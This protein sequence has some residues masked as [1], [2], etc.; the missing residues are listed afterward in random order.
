MIAADLG[1]NVIS[2]LSGYIALRENGEQCSTV[3]KN[4]LYA[5]V[6][7]SATVTSGSNF[8][9]SDVDRSDKW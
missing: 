6:V 8:D 9:S 7:A 3:T 4:E 2:R 1:S 5:S